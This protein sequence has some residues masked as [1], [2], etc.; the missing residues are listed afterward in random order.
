MG[1]ELHFLIF[2]HAMH[3]RFVATWCNPPWFTPAACKFSSNMCDDT[4]Y[5]QASVPQAA[6]DQGRLI[7]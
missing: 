6:R 5:C 3:S 2:M 4:L 1:S 7:G